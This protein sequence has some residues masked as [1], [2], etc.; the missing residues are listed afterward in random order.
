MNENSSGALENAVGKPRVLQDF[1][2]T[3]ERIYTVGM[4]CF[5]S[6]LRYHCSLNNP[7]N[8]SG[9]VLISSG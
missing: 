2:F 9:L 7:E 5:A 3:F 6:A 8:V 4:D 1:H